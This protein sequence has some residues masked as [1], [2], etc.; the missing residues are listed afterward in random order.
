[1]ISWIV[2]TLNV[3]RKGGKN[4]MQFLLA[5]HGKFAE[6]GLKSAKMIFGEI[7]EN[8]K[9]LS[10]E[11]GG[12]GI[13]DFETKAILLAK[14][15]QEDKVLIMAD[16]FGGSPFMKLLSAFRDVDYKLITGF[17]LAMII[18]AFQ[19][20]QTERTLDEECEVLEDCGKNLGIKIVEKIV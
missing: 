3:F 10:L 8:F 17:N 4:H 19:D 1:M 6:E 18:Q 2:L 20:S 14:E 16:L 7:P 11:D 13:D 15:L 12:E 9:V 5:S